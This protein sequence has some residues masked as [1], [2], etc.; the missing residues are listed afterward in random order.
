MGI[1]QTQNPLLLLPAPLVEGV[2]NGSLLLQGHAMNLVV[3]QEV[4]LTINHDDEVDEAQ[5]VPQPEIGN[6][7][8]HRTGVVL[9]N[10][11]LHTPWLISHHFSHSCPCLLLM[12]TGSSCSSQFNVKVCTGTTQRVPSAFSKSW[13]KWHMSDGLIK[14]AAQQHLSNGAADVAGVLGFGL[15]PLAILCSYA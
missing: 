11:H 7:D 4:T 12:L 1:M 2:I 5:G 13:C 15:G 14:L 3:T 6:P 8:V 9:D 10:L